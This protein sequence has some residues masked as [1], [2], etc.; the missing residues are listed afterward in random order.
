MLFQLSAEGI[1][2][3]SGSACTSESLACSHVL[4]DMNVPFMAI[5]GSIRFSFSRYNTEED[6]ERIIAV[7]P[8]VV[9]NVRRVSP[10]WDQ[11][12]NVPRTGMQGAGVSG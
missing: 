10:Y 2:M 7:F 6:I 1:C 11:Q 3:S 12:A 4:S 5:H 9:A 8:G